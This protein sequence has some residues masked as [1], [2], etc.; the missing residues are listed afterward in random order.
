MIELKDVR[1]PLD[2]EL[3]TACAKKLRVPLS[4]VLEAK[5]LRRSVDARKKDDVHFTVTAAVAV[6][7]HNG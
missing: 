5:L 7:P 6:D 2:G 4:D 3:K 1:L